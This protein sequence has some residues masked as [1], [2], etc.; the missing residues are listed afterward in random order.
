MKLDASVPNAARVYNYLLG[1]KDNFAVDREL[2][3]KILAI[4]PDTADVCRDNRAFLQR[5][6][7]FLA[8]E[9]GVRQFLDIGTG[10]PTM[11]SVHQVA[12]ETTP[13]SRVA[14]VDYD[15]VVVAH[16]RALLA[17][18]RDVIAVNG[19]LRSPEAIL[20]D[21]GVRQLID[22]SQPVAV[23]LV[24]V[25]HFVSD[26]E[27]PYE[28]VRTIIDALPPGS[29]LVLTQSTPDDV[30]NDVTEAMKDVYSGASAQVT[31]RSFE[32]IARFFD[33]LELID[34]ELVNVTLWRPDRPSDQSSPDPRRSLI[35]GGVG[36]KP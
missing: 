20:T 28:A 8:L 5:A 34:P 16:A 3:Q 31:P 26:A 4:L 21:A 14:Y 32:E 30:P 17:S 18:G 25:L 19:D 10:L 13:D 36:L 12:Q 29:Y 33:G 27:R 35:Y 23:L 11:G 15:P 9:A 24:A 1:G 22:F 6:V 7:R 2:A